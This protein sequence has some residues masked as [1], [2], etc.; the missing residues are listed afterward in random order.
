MVVKVKSAGK[1]VNSVVVNCSENKTPVINKSIDV[2]ANLNSGLS[3]TK[4]VNVAKA[5]VGDLIKYTI[6]VKNNGLSDATGIKVWDILPIT[7]KYNSGAQSFDE[8]TR[9]ASWTIDKIEAKQSTTVTLFVNVTGVGNITNTA[10]ANCNENKTVVNKTSN[11]VTAIPNVVLS[12]VKEANVTEP[13]LVGDKIK[14]TIVVT[15][16]G[17]SDATQVKVI[18]VIDTSL[19]KIVSAESTPGYDSNIDGWI[20]PSIAAKGANATLYLVVSVITN[21]TISNSVN[22]TCSENKTNVTNKS[23]D[24]K[25]DSFVNL[26]VSKSV[27]VTVQDVVLVGDKIKYTIVVTNN[28]LS[29][30]T[31]INVTDA[32][33]ISLVEVIPSESSEGYGTVVANGWRIASLGV[34]M[35]TTLYLVVRVT[36]AGT[37]ANSVTVKSTENETPVTNKSD[38]VTSGTVVLKVDKTSDA[39]GRVIVGSEV[40][41]II[42]F[43]NI[44]TMNATGVKITDKLADG[45]TF[46]KASDGGIFS[47]GVVTWNIGNLT[48]NNPYSVEVIVKVTKPGEYN[49]TAIVTSKENKTET[50]GTTNITVI[51]YVD[52]DVVKVANVTI[53]KVGE[54]IKFI[55][56][57]TNNGL[58]NATN[59]KVSDKLNDAFAFN[60]TDG[61]YDSLTNNVNWTIS[62]IASGKFAEVYVIV[63]VQYEGVF[64][65][66][67]VV[68]S[69]EN[70][71]KSNGTEVIVVGE[72]V[73]L[74]INKSAN[75]TEVKVGDEIKFTITVRNIGTSDA[76]DVVITD[77]L[78]AAFGYVSGGSYDDETRTVTLVINK[79]ASCSSTDVHVIVKALSN[80]T[81][82]NNVTAYCLENKTPVNASSE[83]ITVGPFVNLAMDKFANVTG[84][85]V[86]DLIEYTIVVANN[87]LSDATGVKV[88]DIL[89][90]GVEY[91][92]GGVYDP[93]S[94][95]VAW[96]IPSI[97]AGDYNSVTLVVN[98]IG[99]GNV[100]NTVFANSEENDTVV[101]KTSDGVPVV[102]NV[103]LT[104]YKFANVTGAVVG[105]LIEYTIVVANNGLSDA[106]GVKVWDI[107]PVGVEY[108]SG[109]VYDPI[110]RIVAWIIPSIAA[111]DYNSVTLVVNVIGA[112]NVVNT[113]FA[114]SEENDTVVNKTSDGVPVVPNVELTMYK[115]AN[116]TSAV[117]GYNIMFTIKVTNNG[118][119]DATN[120]VVSDELDVVFAYIEGGAYEEA[121]RIV[122]WTISTIGAGQS[123]DVYVVVRVLTNGTFANVVSAYAQENKTLVNVTSDNVTVNPD[124]RLGMVKVSNVTTAYVGDNIKFIITITND[125][126]SDATNVKIEDILPG[127]VKFISANGT[128]VNDGQNVLWTIDKIAG[129]S[130]VSVYVVV[131]AVAAGSIVNFA[132][133]TCNEN[134]TSK[135]NTSK[136]DIKPVVDLSVVKT[137][138]VSD[139][140]VG[141]KVGYN[142]VV[143]NNGPCDANNIII[144]D[145][146]PD[147]LKFVSSNI[148]CVV[149]DNIVTWTVAKLTSDEM[150][151]I[152]VVCI[153]VGSGDLTNTVIVTCDENKT[154]ST[155]EV[156]IHVSDLVDVSI[157]LSVD[158]S[159]PDINGVVILTLKVRNNG[160]STATGIVGK[161]K[162]M[163]TLVRQTKGGPTYREK[164][165]RI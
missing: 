81:F 124:V 35:N 135:T 162:F 140:Y 84:A 47:N 97:A 133:V 104:M 112:G 78:D 95:I 3:I 23:D 74:E 82:V 55:I 125:G 121:T 134:S 105:D 100:V 6:I 11:N 36:D 54:F 160:P 147:G 165:M 10:F 152:D 24:V 17:L 20:V 114:N 155:G 146:L 137:A 129:K 109:G 69:D 19:V 126:L 86:G 113:V 80:G 33:D 79:V 70:K 101:N 30:A 117:V 43:E 41:F 61:V 136:I 96:I 2:D 66:T 63:K 159:T 46:I 16:N 68:Y 31:G 34:G 158:N 91:V 131:N 85:V 98:V 93:I 90:V 92:S 21:G 108:V 75:V 120:V 51:P 130:K 111:G 26:T 83:N 37:I 67:A 119:S 106:T 142:I 132:N 164:E 88:W 64:N 153:V 12:V 76:I 154:N 127:S 39:S 157:E 110:S 42:T 25:A 48:P 8:N 163:G 118:L 87:G 148:E 22:V 103:E 150:I 62:N 99:A 149:V 13:V 52:L 57:V 102:P 50:N 5:V 123:E 14:Y 15:N 29:T 1:I 128:Y 45:L 32:V 18:D 65:N 94:R 156:P 73:V 71:T 77:I 7:V 89:P 143:T 44:G 151:I 139:I 122:T 56:T 60:G 144:V 27:N 161:L 9:N 138:N 58:S 72:V 107:L 28:G 141:D 4:E 115:F 145:E 40:R 116:V 53:V 59:V 49:N 38:N